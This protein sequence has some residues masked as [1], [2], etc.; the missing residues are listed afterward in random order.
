M[1]F[2]YIYIIHWYTLLIKNIKNKI[3]N[4]ITN[5]NHKTYATNLNVDSNEHIKSDEYEC[6]IS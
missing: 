5:K 2:K 3:T 6:G 1:Q 4:K